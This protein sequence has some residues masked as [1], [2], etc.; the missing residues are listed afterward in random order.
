MTAGQ[1]RWLATLNAEFQ[2]NADHPPAPDGNLR[3]SRGGLVFV[4]KPEGRVSVELAG[5]SF[6]PDVLD[7]DGPDYNPEAL[8]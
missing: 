8:L 1:K 5:G 6:I 4:I 3:I 2:M 7:S